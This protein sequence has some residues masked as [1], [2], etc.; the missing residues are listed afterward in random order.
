MHHAAQETIAEATRHI[1]F[2][3]LQP[4]HAGDLGVPAAAGESAAAAGRLNWSITAASAPPTISAIAR[5]RPARRPAAGRLVDRLQQ[6]PMEQRLQQLAADKGGA[7]GRYAQTA[8][9]Q[10]GITTYIGLEQQPAAPRAT[11]QCGAGYRRAAN[12]PAG[13]CVHGFK[14][15][16]WPGAARLPNAV[17]RLETTLEPGQL[18]AVLQDIER[19][20]GAS[21]ACAGATHPS[22]LDILLYGDALIDSPALTIPHPAL[23]TRNFVLYPEEVSGPGLAAAR[24]RSARQPVDQCPCG[25]L[26][27]TGLHLGQ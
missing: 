20:Q 27:A 25:E 11:A 7:A 1:P 19:A 8:P 23:H 10:R 13:G 21:A 2:P 9:A 26:V 17:L 12:N 18:L 6:L 3:P 22:T 15:G 24:W 14:P 16:R 4:A 5:S